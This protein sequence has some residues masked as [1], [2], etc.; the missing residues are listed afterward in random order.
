MLQIF[1]KNGCIFIGQIQLL[2]LRFTGQGIGYNVQRSLPGQYSDGQLIHPFEPTRL[3]ST[4]IWL[5]KY[6]L[7]W[8]VVGTYGSRYTINVTSPLDTCLEDC[9]QLFLAPTIVAFCWSVLATMVRNGVQTI[10]ILLQQNSTSCI[11][12]RI[13]I[14]HE[15]LL[16]IWQFQYSWVAQ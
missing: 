4:K 14:N 6:M 10:I 2:A 5:H 12:T 15:W 9:Q 8:F 11:L 3:T 7:T 13:G 16:K 1:C